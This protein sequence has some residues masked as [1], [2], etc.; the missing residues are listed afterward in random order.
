[1]SSLSVRLGFASLALIASFVPPLAYLLFSSESQKRGS[2]PQNHHSPLTER[3][4]ASVGIQHSV[5]KVPFDPKAPNPFAVR[6][7]LPVGEVLFFDVEFGPGGATNIKTLLQVVFT[8]GSEFFFF[9]LH[10]PDGTIPDLAPLQQVLSS[11]RVYGAN[12]EA[13]DC[14]AL[15]ALGLDTQNVRDVMKLRP[16]GSGTGAPGPSLKTACVATGVT[17]YGGH[18]M[19][20]VW[21]LYLVA[22]KLGM[23]GSL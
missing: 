10:K 19:G 15:N 8:N 22:A 2:L 18:A 1:M 21:S 14:V 5:P 17:Y 3:S 12:P 23:L 13:G 20:E 16:I 7:P 11:N 6:P 4:F 9:P